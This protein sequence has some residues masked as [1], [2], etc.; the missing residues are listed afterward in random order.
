MS[1]EAPI[2]GGVSEE[3]MPLPSPI[4]IPKSVAEILTEDLDGSDEIVASKGPKH[5]FDTGVKELGDIADRVSELS[6]EEVKKA[7]ER[8]LAL[9]AEIPHMTPKEG[10][11]AEK[12]GRVAELLRA[13]HVFEEVIEREARK[14]EVPRVE[15]KPAQVLEKIT[16]TAEPALPPSREELER[17]NRI[18]AVYGQK[19]KGGFL[20]RMRDFFG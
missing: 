19:P 8:A 11:D 17:L 7:N 18:R 12:R 4:E 2:L 16:P 9:A 15:T 20:G 1:K 3:K 10:E 13:M 6:L 5:D 14:R